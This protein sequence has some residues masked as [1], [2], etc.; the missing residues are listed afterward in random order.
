MKRTYQL[1]TLRDLAKDAG[2]CLKLPY[3]NQRTAYLALARLLPRTYMPNT[4]RVYHC[5]SCDAYHV[6]H[7]KP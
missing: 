2:A 6:G 5:H 4:L 7:R 1:T 3:A